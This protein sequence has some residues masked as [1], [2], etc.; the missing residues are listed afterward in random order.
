MDMIVHPCYRGHPILL[1]STLSFFGFGFAHG[2]GAGILIALLCGGFNW[3]L[4]LFSVKGKKYIFKNGLLSVKH[5]TGPTKSMRLNQVQ[6]IDVK[7]RSFGAGDVVLHTPSGKV[8][9]KKI[10]H[11]QKLADEIQKQ[12]S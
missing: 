8:A 5:W 10:R 9:I 4:L 3:A 7:I 12:I 2:S 1:F 11:A 6:I